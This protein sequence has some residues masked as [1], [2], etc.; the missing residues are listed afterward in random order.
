MAL[1]DWNNSINS[2]EISEIKS[3]TG[4]GSFSLIINPESTPIVPL[5]LLNM[6]RSTQQIRHF[7]K[8]IMVFPH[9]LILNLQQ[10]IN[11][12]PYT[13]ILPEDGC[14]TKKNN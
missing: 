5:L 7:S 1:G 10:M 2:D 12:A 8:Q 14:G 4:K 6:R 11:I 3:I 13:S 9:R